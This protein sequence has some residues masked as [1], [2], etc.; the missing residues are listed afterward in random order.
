MVSSIADAA[1]DRLS[2][3]DY[4]RLR[5]VCTE[6]RSALAPPFPILLGLADGGR[7]CAPVRASVF[8]L[9]ARRSFR[10]LYM[11][12]SGTL[13]DRLYDNPHEP[14]QPVHS[15]AS[16]VGSGSGR[17]ATARRMSEANTGRRGSSSSIPARAP[18][19]RPSSAKPEDWPRQ[20]GLHRQGG[21]CGRDETFF[22]LRTGNVL[23]GQDMR[24]H[25]LVWH[26][27]QMHL[28]RPK[29]VVGVWC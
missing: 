17:L 9:P 16:I 21:N 27:R 14:A 4:L 20:G 24:H 22:V 18:A 11:G 7:R 5:G 29:I 15:R 12:R 19:R 13:S 10:D 8:S 28:L 25:D 23:P 2:L 3:G 26:V 6:W 1:G